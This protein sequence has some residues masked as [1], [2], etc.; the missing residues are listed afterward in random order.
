MEYTATFAHDVES[1]P[2]VI[3]RAE[4]FHSQ[5]NIPYQPL[6]NRIPFPFNPRLYRHI[7]QDGIAA[8]QKRAQQVPLCNHRI[9][10]SDGIKKL[11]RLGSP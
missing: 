3:F 7:P 9:M 11:E 2:G 1:L 5:R 10:L 6:N 8:L 4:S